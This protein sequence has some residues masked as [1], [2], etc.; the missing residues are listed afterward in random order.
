MNTFGAGSTYNWRSL[1]FER[2]YLVAPSM[3]FL[4]NA[5]FSGSNLAARF[6]MYLFMNVTNCFL[7]KGG[8]SCKQYKTFCLTYILAGSAKIIATKRSEISH[9]KPKGIH[10]VNNLGNL[11]INTFILISTFCRRVCPN[12]YIDCSLN[13]PLPDNKTYAKVRLSNYCQC[14]YIYIYIYIISE[15]QAL[16]PLRSTNT[17]MT[18]TIMDNKTHRSNK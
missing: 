11:I 9:L 4:N 3:C 10:D 8:C 1:I 12:V 15:V 16:D 6:L 5:W 13:N 17:N 18:P 2:R 14:I 7:S